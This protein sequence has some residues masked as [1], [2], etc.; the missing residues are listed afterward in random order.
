MTVQDAINQGAE[1]MSENI[2]SVMKEL[3]ETKHQYQS[4]VTSFDK[5]VL[6]AVEST[7]RGLHANGIKHGIGRLWSGAW[8]AL[9]QSQKRESP[10]HF[11]WLSAPTGPSILAFRIPHVKLFCKRCDRVEAFNHVSGW[12]VLETDVGGTGAT[13]DENQP[14]TQIFVLSFLCQSCKGIP[15]VFLVRRKGEK[16]TLSGRS[17]IEH[18]EQP[19]DIPKPISRYYSD[20][21]VAH[22]SGQTLAGVFLFRV[23]I[24]QWVQSQTSTKGL[25]ADSALEE[26][27][28]GLPNDF[29]GR[30]PSFRELYERLSTDIHSATGSADLFEEARQKIVDHFEAR[31]LFKLPK[32]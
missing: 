24:E 3:L 16:L 30:F 13:Q 6:G 23:L 8:H 17:P 15:E 27:M 5:V 14:T 7:Y 25:K 21:I 20:A 31:R 29:K 11:L 10:A 18:V 12:D 22:Q 4:I 32:K 19:R 28:G 9:P 26:Y 2:T 1:A